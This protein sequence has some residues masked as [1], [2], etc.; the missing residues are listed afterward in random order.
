MSLWIFVGAA[1]LLSLERLSYLW[2]WRAP[3]RFRALC[4]CPPLARIGGP[5]DVLRLFFCVFKIL[6]CVVFFTWCYIYG[7]GSLLP[8]SGSV[9]S[10]GLGAMMVAVG[11]GLNAAVFYRLGR[12]GVFY[13]NKFG[14]EVPWSGKFP[15]SWMRHPQYAGAVLSIWGFFLVMRFPHDDW[16]LLP[17]VETVY[18][19]LG[20][21]FER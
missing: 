1:A 7:Q 15:F 2:I 4:A 10:L 20:A 11:Q 8:L 6:Q 9:W 18:Y 12:I 21:Y 19:A 17:A 3:E 16:Y 5:V 14:H 13:G